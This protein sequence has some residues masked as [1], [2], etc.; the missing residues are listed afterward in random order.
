MDRHPIKLKDSA[1]RDHPLVPMSP[2]LK[3]W[4]IKW[5]ADKNEPLWRISEAARMLAM[6]LDEANHD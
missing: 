4:S 1:E 3:A 5:M 2:A 6:Q